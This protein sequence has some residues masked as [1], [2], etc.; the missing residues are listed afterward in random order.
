MKSR[1]VPSLWPGAQIKMSFEKKM[2]RVYLLIFRL[3]VFKHSAKSYT[4]IRVEI[5]ISRRQ[6]SKD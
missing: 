5:K 1:A 2:T 4:K 3:K 6:T